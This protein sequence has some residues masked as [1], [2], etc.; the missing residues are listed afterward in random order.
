M[1]ITSKQLRLYA[2]T[3]RSGLGEKSLVQAVSEAIDGGATIIQLREK[4]MEETELR[5]LAQELCDLCKSR[6]VLFIVNDSVELAAA[7]D[8][9]GV[10][11]GLDDGSIEEA[12]KA[13]G[14]DKII[15]ASAHN[16]EE[17]LAAQRAGAD[18]LGCGAV[19]ASVTKSNIRPIT[20]AILKAVTD[21][22]S[23]PVVAI[24]GISKENIARLNHCGLAGVAVVSAIFSQP[25]ITAAAKELCALAEQL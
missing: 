16:P 19:F 9:D 18:Y 23:I 4:A 7:V 21:V 14:P 17:A 25:D 10:H 5:K 3:E 24:G 1:D 2:V 8:A 11:L 6:G 12:R 15:G 13:L 20:P 22:V